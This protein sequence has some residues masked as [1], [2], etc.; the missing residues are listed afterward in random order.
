MSPKELKQKKLED[1]H[2]ALM[3]LMANEKI[4]DISITELCDLAGVSRTYFYHHFTSMDDVIS[5]FQVSSIVAYMRALPS[6]QIL[7]LSTMMQHYFRLNQESYEDT[8]ILIRAGKESVLI[9]AFKSVYLYLFDKNR[10]SKSQ[11]TNNKYWADFI[12]GAVVNMMVAWL[13]DG[14]TESATAMG[15]NVAKFLSRN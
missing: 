9:K 12:A 13:Q 3:T 4:E 14:M 11:L 15:E 8:L 2:K 5:E 1:T 10:I 6:K 7:D